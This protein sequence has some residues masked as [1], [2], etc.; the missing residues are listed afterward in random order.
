MQKL[1]LYIE[2]ER[3]DMFEDETVSLTQTIQN[4]KD[5]SKIFTDFSKT[6]SLPASKTNNKIFK[7][8]YNYDIVSGFDGRKKKASNLELNNLPFKNGKIKL[9]GVDLKNNLPTTYR[10]TFFGNTVELKDL[11]GEDKL[12]SLSSLTALNKIYDINAIKAGLQLNPNLSTSS[13]IVPL[14]THTDR[15]IY[16]STANDNQAGNVF[17]QNGYYR[18]VKFDQLKYALRLQSIIE[19]IET[20]YSI[21]FSDDFFV[22]T[23]AP[24]Y[25]LFMWL[26]RK[27]GAVE[28]T[29]NVNQSIVNGFTAQS[30]DTGTQT[31]LKSSTTLEFLGNPNGYEQGLINQLIFSTDNATDPYNFYIQIDGIQERAFTNVVGSKTVENF[32]YNGDYTIYIEAATNITF[33]NI[34]WNVQYNSGSAGSPS[35]SSKVYS[36]GSYDY[37]SEFTFDIT[38]QIPE[39]KVIDFLSGIFRMF[40]LTAFIED[41]IIIVKTLDSFYNSGNSYDISKYIDVDSSSVNVALPYRQINFEHEDT[42]TFLSAKHKQLFGKTWGLIN[43]EAQTTKLDGSIYS[44]KTPFSQ[45]KYERLINSNNNTNTTVQYGFFVDDNQDSYF[46]QPLIFYPIRQTSANPISF[47]ETASTHSSLTTY[48]IPSNSVA[49][50]PATSSYNMN[51]FNETNEY[52]FSDDFTN[53]LFEAYYKNYISSVFNEQNR[54]TNVTAILPLRILLNYTLADRFIIN[55]RSFKINSITTNLNTGKSEIELLNDL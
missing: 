9:E 41:D 54:L 46:G 51:F 39:M 6:F 49:L 43:Y 23:N 24:F 32:V 22:S 12:S 20:N 28:S 7:H 11:L 55:N 53:T 21:S 27:K 40:N 17:Y 52:E 25:N 4:V 47:V 29:G 13:V 5:I 10:V 30:I 1:Q 2:G 33:T 45:L 38:Q 50:N 48:I 26:H 18:G 36:T 3:V 44:I 34:Q 14:I 37:V 31:H 35:V 42:K 16:N 8:Y 15:L 19:A